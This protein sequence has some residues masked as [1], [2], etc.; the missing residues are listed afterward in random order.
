[1]AEQNRLDFV[2]GMRGVAALY[3]VF[4][5]CCTMV[6]PELFYL[7]ATAEPRWL[8]EVFRFFLNGHFAVSAF[9]VISGFCLQWALYSRDDGRLVDFGAF[10]KRR[11]RRILPPYYA[12]LALS[13]V[14]CFTVTQ[15]QKGLPW[16]QYLPVTWEN[17]FAHVFMV[18]N[19]NRDWMYKINGV[20]WSIAIEFQ[21]YLLMPLFVW[22]LWRLGGVLSSVLSMGLAWGVVLW[23]PGAEKLYPWYGALF[24]LGMAG[25]WWVRQPMRWRFSAAHWGWVFF[26]FFALALVSTRMTKELWI[27]DAL[28]GVATVAVLCRG[29]MNPSAWT[30]K[31]FSWRPLVGLGAFSYSLYLMHHPVIQVLYAHRPSWVY[32][33]L[34]G[35]AYLL[36]LGIPLIL[37]VTYAFYWVFERPFVKTKQK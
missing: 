20:L 22:M 2:E 10:M 28:M 19:L 24:V 12:C 4:Q 16:S 25:A 29:A 3:V 17:F 13:L 23:V 7:R 18:H 1:M 6:D 35:L 21:L 11:C 32:S 30:A 8:A 33:D 37:V 31:A 26:G 15:H 34:R 27:R 36:G 5:H 9:I 14:T